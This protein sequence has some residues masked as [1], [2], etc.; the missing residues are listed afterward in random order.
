MTEQISNSNT[1]PIASSQTGPLSQ[2]NNYSPF[3]EGAE[4][5]IG[6]QLNPVI[7]QQGL[8]EPLVLYTGLQNLAQYDHHACTHNLSNAKCIYKCKK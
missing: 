6:N 7:Q 1:I 2:K 4:D 3:M 5:V 8:G